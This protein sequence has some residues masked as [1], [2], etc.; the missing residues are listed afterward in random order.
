MKIAV[1][2][3]GGVGGYFGGRLA[4][5]GERVAFIARG[6]HLD[7]ISRNGLVVESGLGSFSI[8]PAWA[9]ADAAAVGP[10]D[11]VLLGVKTWQV[12]EAA[13]AIRPLLGADT[14][15]VPL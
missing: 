5:A 13:Q 3:V 8:Q 15:V 9:E 14:L 7:A 4:Q 6:A 2:G 11:V 10:V 1:F 12:P